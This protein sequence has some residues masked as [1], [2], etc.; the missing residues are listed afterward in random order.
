MPVKPSEQTI[1]KTYTLDELIDLAKQRAQMEVREQM[2]EARSHLDALSQ[3]MGEKPKSTASLPAKAKGRVA[4]SKAKKTKSRRVTKATVKKAKAVPAVKA[5]DKSGEIKMSLGAHLTA[6][7]RAKPMDIKTITAA[8]AD[9]GY[10]SNSNDPRRILY[11]ELKK[12]IDKG[13]VLKAGRG[14]Y[15]KAKRK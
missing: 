6:V 10:T 12:Q 5:S 11:L 15:K 14:K 7:L 2:N 8:L 4:K 3:A 13:T 9:H 1:L